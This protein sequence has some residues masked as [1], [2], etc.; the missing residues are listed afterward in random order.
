MSGADTLP[1]TRC[2]RPLP[3]SPTAR[4]MPA[5]TES[6]LRRFGRS[7]IQHPTYKAFSE[8]GR[9]IKTIFLC[10]YLNDEALRREINDRLNVIE[11]WNSGID[12]IFY[13]K[14]SELTGADREDQEISMLAMHLLQASLVL[15]NTL[16][17]Q[18]ILSE[19]RWAGRLTDRDKKAL[20]ALIWAHIN[21]YGTF[22]I[23][24]NTHLDLEP[25]SQ[26]A[27]AA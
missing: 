18:Q 24:M 2:D 12:F 8:L 13:G 20:T 10:R 9:A 17:I 14:N 26:G 21:P 27:Q 6:I 1:S 15:V 19:P 3:L 25:P 4:C 23:D 16:I 5:E 11:H 22:H 7:N